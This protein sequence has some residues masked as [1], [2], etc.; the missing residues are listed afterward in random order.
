V[1]P[2]LTH[3]PLWRPMLWLLPLVDLVARVLPRPRAVELQRIGGDT[4]HAEL[5]CANGK[6]DPRGAIV[7]FHGGAFLFGGVASHRRIVARLAELTGLPVLSV[8]YRQLPFGLLHDAIED[9][10]AAHDWLVDLGIDPSTV[11]L[12]GDS[13]GGHLA[14]A[15]ALELKRLGRERPAGIVGLSPWLDFDHTAK[16]THPNAVRDVAIPATR[17]APVAR[18]CVGSEDVHPDRSPVNADLDGL[19]P[20]LMHCSADEVLRHDAE[21]MAERLEA[22]GVPVLLNVWPGMVHAFPILGK[23]LKESRTALQELAGFVER[24]N[25]PAGVPVPTGSLA[26]RLEEARPDVVTLPRAVRAREDPFP[27]L[28]PERPVTPGRRVLPCQR[29]G[30]DNRVEGVVA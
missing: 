20:V 17:L 25:G 14:F 15:T 19:P 21:L 16:L 2:A 6:I 4:W 13:A 22:A 29:P 3:V 11:V 18:L 24:V 9:S 10:V 8:G 7:Y 27:P 28:P 23:A 12:V 1:R 30:G 5:V 26:A